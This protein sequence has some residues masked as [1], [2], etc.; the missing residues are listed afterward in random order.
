MLHGSTHILLD[1]T[2]AVAG[3]QDDTLDTVR[4]G[5]GLGSV[6]FTLGHRLTPETRVAF[7]RRFAATVGELADRIEAGS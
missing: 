1:G 3:T 6:S 4:V 2:E 5:D 7:L